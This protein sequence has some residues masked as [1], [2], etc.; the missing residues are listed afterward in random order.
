MSCPRV[1][2]FARIRIVA[3]LTFFTPLVYLNANQRPIF[4]KG[5]NEIR[6]IA[7]INIAETS[8]TSEDVKV[9]IDTGRVKQMRRDVLHCTNVLNEIELPVPMLIKGW[10]DAVVVNAA[11]HLLLIRSD[12]ITNRGRFLCIDGSVIKCPDVSS[13][14]VAIG[15][16]ILMS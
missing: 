13:R 2:S 1:V 4:H 3:F 11:L 12:W 9:V 10:S 8:L 6:I 5:P 16:I 14:V 7:A 15:M